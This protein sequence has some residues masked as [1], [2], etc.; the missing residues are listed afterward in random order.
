[1]TGTKYFTGRL[2]SITYAVP[3]LPYP[4]KVNWVHQLALMKAV[5]GTKEIEISL[6]VITRNSIGT[7]IFKILPHYWG[8][9]LVVSRAE[10]KKDS[11]VSSEKREMKDSMIQGRMH[12]GISIDTSTY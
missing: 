7:F 6:D 2:A 3:S 4:L 5:D 10:R 11:I 1:M 9:R 8:V 12:I